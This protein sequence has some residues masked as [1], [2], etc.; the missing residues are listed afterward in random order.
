MILAL[1]LQAAVAPPAPWAVTTKVDAASKAT[2][3][4]AWSVD[5]TAR[6][7][8]RC[9]VTSEK[10]VSIQFIPKPGFAAA[11]P[12]PVSIKADDDGWLGTNWQFPGTG[13]FIS[14]DVIVTNLAVV[15]AH[16]KTIHV[17][18]IDPDNAVVEA[19]FAGPGE[20]PIRQV[21][22]A[23]DY[24]FGV[25]PARFAVPLAPAAAPDAKPRPDPADD[26]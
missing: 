26:E 3:S 24:E 23:C 17:R 1:L 8:V 5:N 13:A 9:D 6:L 7:V 10:I 14:Q 16:G 15:I 19:S 2:T 11:L 12:R 20:A 18:V 25:A 22:K 4:S 21:L